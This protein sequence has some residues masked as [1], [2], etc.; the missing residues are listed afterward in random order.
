M[1]KPHGAQ[2]ECRAVFYLLLIQKIYYILSVRVGLNF[3]H[4]VDNCAFF[5]YDVSRTHHAE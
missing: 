2:N 4:D 1:K 3:G 5:I